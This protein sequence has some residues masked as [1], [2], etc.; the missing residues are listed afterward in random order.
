[1]S[2]DRK[3]VPLEVFHHALTR[4]EAPLHSEHASQGDK[5]TG[6]QHL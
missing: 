2:R 1:V 4:M 6:F 5:M 3:H